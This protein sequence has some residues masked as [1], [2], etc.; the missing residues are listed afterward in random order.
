M[1]LLLVWECVPE[2]VNCYILDPS[3]EQ[4]AWA[5]KC[6]GKYVNAGGDTEELSKLNDW[7]ATNEA[8]N[9]IVD[10]EKPIAGPFSEVVVCGFVM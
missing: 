7:L 1:K 3:S 4:A 9:M 10:N 8:K 5:R 2:D 6:A